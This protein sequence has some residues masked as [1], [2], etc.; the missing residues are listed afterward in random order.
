VRRAT[1]ILFAALAAL[2][3]P[4]AALASPDAAQAGEATMTGLHL[5][6]PPGA[7]RSTNN[8]VL[9]WQAGWEDEAAYEFVDAP[10]APAGDH[11]QRSGMK[12]EITIPS[13]PG[14]AEPPSREYLVKV[15]LYEP[16]QATR[17]PIQYVALRF[18]DSAPLP[19]QPSAPA[20]WV[21]GRTPVVATIEHP[22]GLPPSGL[23]GY[24]TA[25]SGHPG[26]SPCATPTH[27]EPSEVDLPGGVGDDR[28]QLGPLPDGVNFLNV[29]AVSNMGVASAPSSV[30]IRV[31]ANPPQVRFAGVPAGWVDH[32]VAVTAIAEDPSSGTA[33][34]GPSGPFT[35]LAVDGGVP[36]FALGGSAGTTVSGEGVHRLSG[37]ARDAVGNAEGPEA[38]PGATVRIDETPPRVAFAPAQRPEDPELIEVAVADDR[39]GPSADRGTIELRPLGT[40]QRFQPLPTRATAA[41]LAARWNSDDFAPGAYEFRATGFDAAGNSSSTKSRTDGSP[42]V[43]RNPVKVP[44]A[45]ESGFG[46]ASLLWQHCHR[47]GGS[48]RCHPEKVTDFESRPA[49]WTVPYGRSLRFGGILR[50]AAG[51]PLA[52]QPVEIVETFAPGADVA[53]R[54]TTVT[55]HAG[56]RFDARLAPGP[57]RRV[58]A[59]FPGTRTLTRAAGRPVTMAARAGLRL[60]ASTETAQIGGD[61]VIFTGRL[62]AEEA[63]IPRTGR[64]VELQFR[65]PGAAWSEFRT[66]QTDRRGRFRYPYAFTDDDSRGIRFQFRAVSPEQSDWPY[67]PSASRPVAVTGY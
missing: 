65:V 10:W 9:E 47:V 11:R 58:E 31:D 51:S 57:S 3:A 56:G 52:G 14:A 46:G 63:T 36:A 45:V 32:P 12:L 8:F 38:L 37:W 33:P 39:A 40:T 20:G 44:T 50:T 64:P 30:P 24:A 67:R 15:W 6:G 16:H 17:G 18:D 19:A 21:D 61:A 48:R 7:W 42:M 27:C 25:V 5:D 55:S 23:R 13:P 29:V 4:I 1:T 34:S 66:V 59:F 41:G 22:A 60:H 35:A 2:V 43:L 53:Q 28:L 49:L 54:R 62:L 26:E